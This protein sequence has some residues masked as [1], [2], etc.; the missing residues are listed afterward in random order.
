M[1]L[2]VYNKSLKY[3]TI[4][5]NTIQ[6][7]TPIRALRNS[8]NISSMLQIKVVVVQVLCYCKK[9]TISLIYD[10]A[11]HVV[12]IKVNKITY[13]STEYNQIKAN[14]VLGNPLR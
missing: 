1:Y 14:Q 2:P 8:S 12:Y 10:G 6:Y 3:N 11:T 13:M 9:D 4:Q 5:N 7:N